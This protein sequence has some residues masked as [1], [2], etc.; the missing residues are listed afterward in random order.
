MRNSIGNGRPITT[1][2][3]LSEKKPYLFTTQI[4]KRLGDWVIIGRVERRMNASS[5]PPELRMILRDSDI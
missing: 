5:H 1:T 4:I 2:E 3:T